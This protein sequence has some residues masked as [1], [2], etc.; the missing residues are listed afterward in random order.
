MF[1]GSVLLPYEK[2]GEA[3]VHF[4]VIVFTFSS[5]NI[6]LFHDSERLIFT[7]LRESFT[8]FRDNFHVF[9]PIIFTLFHGHESKQDETRHKQGT[10]ARFARFGETVLQIRFET[11]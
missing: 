1:H 4:Y 9:H 6:A 2:K 11:C 3:G 8:I 10:M 5:E 7:E